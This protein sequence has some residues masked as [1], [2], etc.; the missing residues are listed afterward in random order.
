MIKYNIKCLTSKK[1][2]RLDQLPLSFSETL[3]LR[4]SSNWILLACSIKK[5]FEQNWKGHR[6][7]NNLPVILL[8]CHVW[9]N[10]IIS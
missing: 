6:K 7:L 5:L 10:G 8:N 3:A 4:S 1:I 2:Y 9:W